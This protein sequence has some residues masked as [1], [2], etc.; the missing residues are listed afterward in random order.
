MFYESGCNFDYD[1]LKFWFLLAR[2]DQPLGPFY[3]PMPEQ[4]YSYFTIRLS[5]STNNG[6]I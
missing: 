6:D 3:R 2:Y 5:M 4:Y 1:F